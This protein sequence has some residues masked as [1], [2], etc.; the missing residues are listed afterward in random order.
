MTAAS[1]EPSGDQRA[2]A[3]R[4]RIA[5]FAWTIPAVLVLGFIAVPMAIADLRAQQLQSQVAAGD[6]EAA[7]RNARSM[8]SIDLFQ[9]WRAD[10]NLG[11]VFL[12]REEGWLAVDPLQSAL[13]RVPEKHRCDV[14]ANL[15]LAYR[16]QVEHR[17]AE[18][19]RLRQEGQDL[20]DSETEPPAGSPTWYE[21]FEQA[22]E[23]ERTLHNSTNEAD[24]LAADESCASSDSDE[25][26]PDPSA[27]PPP[28]SPPSP[29]QSP[30]SG[31]DQNDE[32]Q[33][34]DELQQRQEQAEAD[35]EEE[36]QSSAGGG[37]EGG[38]QEGDGPG[39]GW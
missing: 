11:T 28:S 39:T 16:A 24:R 19:E 26:E 7:L 35:A 1:T 5:W 37:N 12:Y 25:S 3:R 29:S 33:R 27:T 4:S 31:S 32:Q 6:L 34:Q 10:Y 36:R 8:A 18:V 9:R 23:L 14:Q 20:H 2:R 21:L 13:E 38:T 22:L 15:I 17:T 30:Q